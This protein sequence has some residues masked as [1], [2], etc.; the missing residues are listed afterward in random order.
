MT[1]KPTLEDRNHTR[2]ESEGKFIHS[3]VFEN[4]AKSF[5]FPVVEEGFKDIKLIIN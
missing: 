3:T 4:M 1:D 5:T 2:F